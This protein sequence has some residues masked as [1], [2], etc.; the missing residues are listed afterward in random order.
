M[1]DWTFNIIHTVKRL[2]SWSRQTLEERVFYSSLNS[3]TVSSGFMSMW[4]GCAV[5]CLVLSQILNLIQALKDGKS[6]LQLVQMPPVIVET[7]RAPQRANS[8]SYTQSFQSRRPFFTWWWCVPLWAGAWL[9]RD[10]LL[11]LTNCI[12][13]G[14]EQRQCLD[15]RSRGQLPFSPPPPRIK[16]VIS[17]L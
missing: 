7:A 4:N 15:E 2:S 1:T 11:F 14:T 17:A 6:P 12:W 13:E 5:A 10:V 8:E 9:T 16:S 3:S